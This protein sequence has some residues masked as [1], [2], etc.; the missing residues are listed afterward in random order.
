MAISFAYPVSVTLCASYFVQ[1]L[2]VNVYC[3]K[4]VP[5]LS[6]HLAYVRDG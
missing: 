3:D 4:S 6:L 5:V 1:S 2:T